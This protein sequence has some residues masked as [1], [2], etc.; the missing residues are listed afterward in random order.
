[1]IWKSCLSICE[2]GRG[3]RKGAFNSNHIIGIMKQ[4]KDILI[5]FKFDLIQG[6]ENLVVSG[7]QFDS[8]KSFPRRCFSQLEEKWLMVMIT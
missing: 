4:L 3:D 6:D 5:G 2:R 1:M 7:L 8:E